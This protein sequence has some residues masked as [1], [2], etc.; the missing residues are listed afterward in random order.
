MTESSPP[1]AVKPDP[2][3]AFHPL[4]AEWFRARLGEP[5]A[6]QALA[7]P[8]IAAGRHVLLTAP[9]GS[10]KTLAAF[11]WALNRFVTGAVPAAAARV[12]YVSP[13]KALGNDIRQNLER[14]LAEL[15]EL[16]AARGVPF[17]E[18]RVAVRTGDT[19]PG[20]RR[21]IIRRPPEILITTPESMN[22]LLL[23]ASGRRALQG[24]A[25]VI[26]DEIHAVAGEKRGLFLMT[27]VERLAQL[28]GEFQRVA[29]SATVRPAA[30]VAAFVGGYRL[31]SESPEPVYEPRAVAHLDAPG[32]KRYDLRV[33]A[34][35]APAPGEP[36]SHWWLQVAGVPRRDREHRTTLF[37]ANS[38]RL[39]ERLT[40]SINESAGRDVAYSHHG[41]LAREIRAAVEARFKRGELAA[42]V[43]TSSLELGIDIGSVEAVVMVQPPY[44]VTSAVQRIGRAGHGV[45]RTSRGRFLPLHPPALVHAAATARA[46]AEGA[47]EPIVPR[48]GEL[49][50]LAQV[51]LAMTVDDART[52]DEL[53]TEVRCCAAYHGLERRDFDRVVAMLAGRWA[54][55][56]LREL[57]PRLAVDTDRRARAGPTCADCCS[58]RAG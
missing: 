37:F 51:I 28:G 10:G 38:R 57:Q 48:P 9:T 8:A 16:F 49:D 23:S 33:E 50:V 55:T 53:F 39:V 52:L 34:P 25:T 32:A 14:R 45:G 3:A 47:I 36:P 24:T 58:C 4:V 30:A 42:I 18:I 6:A 40:R 19:D 26:L 44:S 46:V 2:L 35:P 13:L 20:E 5:T 43:A 1:P 27:A 31:A 21:R 15:R 41:A 54:G 12:L 17:P 56:R 11:L 29:L 7:W 22:I